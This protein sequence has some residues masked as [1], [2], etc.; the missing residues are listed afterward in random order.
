[1]RGEEADKD[2]RQGQRRPERR[3][4]ARPR[5]PF[6]PE[7]RTRRKYSNRPA[8]LG[9]LGARDVRARVGGATAYPKA[10]GIWRDDERGGAPV[11][12]EPV[13]VHCYTTPADIEGDSSLA[14]RGG[15][16][17]EMGRRAPQ[18]EVGLGA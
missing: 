9:R 15:V 17:R 3:T 7:R 16:C 18:G 12:E 6:R 14:Q 11:K 2:A 13:V 4:Q 5:G 8:A 10:K 1:M